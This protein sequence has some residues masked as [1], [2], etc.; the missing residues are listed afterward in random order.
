MTF[1]N[2]DILSLRSFYSIK[3]FDVKLSIKRL[4]LFEIILVHDI[5]S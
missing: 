3:N 5:N 2:L 1:D 4:I